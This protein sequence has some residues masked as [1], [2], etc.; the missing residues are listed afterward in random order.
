MSSIEI[1]V[2][3]DEG[4]SSIHFCPT[5]Q[6]ILLMSTWSGTMRLY[7]IESKEQFSNFDCNSSLMCST[8]LNDGSESD[9]GTV[10]AGDIDGRIYLA[11]S[12]NLSVLNGHT[13]GISSISV[14]P[15]TGLL[16]SGSWDKSLAMWD[17]SQP[18]ETSLIGHIEFNEKIMFSAAC[19]ENRIVAY[20]NHNTVFVIDARNPE[21]IERRVS[22]LGK[23]IRSFCV[24]APDQFGWAVGSIDGRIAIEYFGDI[25][26]QA[27]RFSFSCNRHEEEEKTI[28]YPVSCLAFH[29]VTGILT[30]G[31]SKGSIYFWDIQNKRKLTE[32]QSPFNN[33]VS[34]IDFNND[35]SLLAIAYSYTW[36]KGNIE[37]PEDRVLI[38][39]P[40]AQNISLSH[41]AE[42]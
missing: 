37:H 23:Q 21:Q 16:L 38:Y 24:S 33:S 29:P 13:D 27:Q 18:P 6:N 12:G 36:E 14:F 32:V 28:V 11:K 3:P 4:I 40:S 7:D 5:N 1:P 22:S 39:Y 25:K 19:T 20:G 42:N 9:I 10:A 8:F 26:H 15:E 41:P 34:A 2:P 35:G 31:S 17:T 30:S